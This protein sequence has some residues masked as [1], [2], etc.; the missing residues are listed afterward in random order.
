MTNC[1]L[2]LAALILQDSGSGMAVNANERV[3]YGFSMNYI[4]DCR[5]SLNRKCN[6]AM[7][8]AGLSRY[9]PDMS[10]MLSFSFPQSFPPSLYPCSSINESLPFFTTL[11]NI[12]SGSSSCGETLHA[13]LA[14]AKSLYISIWS[15]SSKH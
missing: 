7:Q 12:L 13:P 14:S 2:L 10:L 3:C 5:Y 11:Q 15:T 9:P 8:H 1:L 6:Y 4:I